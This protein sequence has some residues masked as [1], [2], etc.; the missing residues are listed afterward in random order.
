MKKSFIF[1]AALTILAACNKEESSV[2][3][4]NTEVI[5][6]QIEQ[7]TS[8]KTYMDAY[9]NIRWSEGD[10]IVG[11]MKSSLGLKYRILPSSVGKTYASFENISD[12]NGNINAGIEWDHNVVY[13]PYSDAVEVVKSG[14]NY[15]L[16][17]VLPSEQTYAP[18]SFANGSMAMVAVSEDNNITFK[19]VLGGIKLQLLG[20]QKVK[21]IKL[22]GNNYEKLSGAATVKAFSDE[23][24]PFITMAS[25]A[26]TSVTLNCGEGVQ[27]NESRATDFIIALPPVVFSEGF[28]VT[29]TDLDNKVY[30]LESSRTNTVIRS[31]LLIMPEQCIDSQLGIKWGLI[32]FLEDNFWERDILMTKDGERVVAK[33]VQFSELT[34]K[35]RDY[36]FWGSDKHII[37]YA[38]GAEKGGINARLAVVTAEYSKANL[39]GYCEDIKINGPSGTYDVYFNYENLEVYVMEPGYKPGEKQPIQQL[40]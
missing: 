19:N 8:T 39:G 6:A 37:G 13:Y 14:S 28:T 30:T 3:S 26:S 27:L 4:Q 11:F 23:S 16:D 36:G 34:F 35:I 25:D 20:T 31:S 7:E 33:S 9:N 5:T 24:N 22:E 29:I 17:V 2:S 10:Q 1:F 40:Y 18:E 32:G 38:P 15:V 21:S 12:S